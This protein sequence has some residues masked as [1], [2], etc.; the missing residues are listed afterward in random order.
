MLTSRAIPQYADGPADWH[1]FLEKVCKGSVKAHEM[2]SYADM[3]YMAQLTGDPESPATLPLAEYK[4][5]LRSRFPAS[6]PA[7]TAQAIFDIGHSCGW[8]PD[9]FALTKWVRIQTTSNLWASGISLPWPSLVSDSIH[10]CLANWSAD[11]LMECMDESPLNYDAVRVTRG[12]LYLSL[13][14]P[15]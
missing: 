1:R 3:A 13:T 8:F 9:D 6:P 10:Q 11:G 7:E 12:M 14:W 5:M 2:L 15:E 4:E